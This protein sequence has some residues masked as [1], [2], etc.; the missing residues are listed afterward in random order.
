MEEL[1]N[2]AKFLQTNNIKTIDD[3]INYMD[4]TNFKISELLSQRERLWAKRKLSRD[5]NQM[6]QITEE[7]SSLNDKIIK[8]RKRVELCEDIKTRIPKINENLDELDTQE[9]L[10]KETK[11]K[12]KEKG[13]QEK[14][15]EEQLEE[16][17]AQ[18][19]IQKE[20]QIPENFNVAK[21]EKSPLSEPSSMTSKVQEGV[22][23]GI[24][25]PS[26]KKELAKL[27]IEAKKLDDLKTKEKAINNGVI[28][29]P[30]KTNK[31]VKS[32]R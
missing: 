11:D 4:E 24:K 13:V 21:I 20:Q 2:E 19:P 14:S 25:K 18:K 15:K 22:S 12:K 23:K 10:E 29:A 31:Q 28:N 16:V 9:E 3:L 26:V 8:F 17:L 32:N 1:S 5:E 6:Y 30:I 27:K 7:I